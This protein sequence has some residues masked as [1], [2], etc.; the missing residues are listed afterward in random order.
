LSGLCNSGLVLTKL[1]NFFLAPSKIFLDKIPQ[2]LYNI[3]INWEKG[4]EKYDLQQDYN[5]GN[6]WIVTQDEDGYRKIVYTLS[7]DLTRMEA[8]KHM[9]KLIEEWEND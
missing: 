3:H 7:A 5:T 1:H 9:N 4:M 8:K 6:W 2:N